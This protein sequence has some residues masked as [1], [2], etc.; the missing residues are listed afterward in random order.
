MPRI[1]SE[2]L[3][4]GS[5][6]SE[7]F[8]GY[9]AQRVFIV[10]GVTGSNSSAKL[11]QALLT[12]GI[13]QVGSFHPS[14]T[15]IKC[16]SRNVSA[17]KSRDIF[18]ITCDYRRVNADEDTDQTE[19]AQASVGATVQQV[20][21]TNDVKGE[22][23]ELGGVSTSVNIINPDTGAKE[24]KTIVP[25]IQTGEVTVQI[26]QITIQFT[27]RITEDPAPIAQKY[28]GKIN[29]TSFLGLNPEKV[30]C[31]NVSANSNDGQLTWDLTF[32]FQ[33]N[34]NLWKGDVFWQDPQTGKPLPGSNES[35]NLAKR[36]DLYEQVDF[37]QLSLNQKASE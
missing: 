20:T 23:I 28:I 8:D 15:G 14:I 32:E 34:Q 3:V 24:T 12:P 31:S 1:E 6:L 2:D 10:S 29:K 18:K 16:V 13:P 25:Q 33:V 11:L 22:P 37:N 30:L 26:P 9:N 4:E 19:Q 17:V 36:V 35:N 21:T 27:K 5:G 7:D